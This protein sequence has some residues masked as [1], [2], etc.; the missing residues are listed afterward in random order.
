MIIESENDER[1][2]N[3]MRGTFIIDSSGM[4]RHFAVNDFGVGR[5]I[6]EIYRLVKA[7]QF[8]DENGQ[9]CPA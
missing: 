5:N 6:E 1:Y 3:I 4:L 2:Q 8:S 7:F 9:V